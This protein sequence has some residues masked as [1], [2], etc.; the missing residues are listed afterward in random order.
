M[1][2][3]KFLKAR[4]P[5]LFQH[6]FGLLM[7]LLCET[8]PREAYSHV[9]ASFGPKKSKRRQDD[10]RR[11]AMPVENWAAKLGVYFT[12]SACKQLRDGF[13]R[14]KSGEDPFDALMGLLSMIDVVEGSRC[15]GGAS[16]SP[17][18]LKWEG[19]ILGQSDPA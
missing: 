6:S 8:Y 5:L 2:N 10:R 1:K 19:W 14:A 11:A 15:E 7:R 9:G 18:I 16:L 4:T 17:E 13:G 3:G 12:A